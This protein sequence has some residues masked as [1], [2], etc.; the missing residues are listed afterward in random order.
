MKARKRNQSQIFMEKAIQLAET[1]MN[2]KD[3]G[4]FG[5]IL[6]KDNTII[7]EG[8]NKVTSSNDPTAHAEIVCIREA[9][10]YLQN[11]DLSDCEI[12]SS[13]EP[14]PMCLAA[15]YW[16]GIKRITYGADHNEAATYGFNDAFIY[17]E[18]QKDRS[19]RKIEMIQIMRNE[20]LA[21][22]KQ[23]EELEDKIT[24]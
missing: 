20:A 5:A 8:W 1:H 9:A 24:Y 11:F 6:V 12:F 14:C 21:G 19:A 15:A 18:L 3:G 22:F 23:W 16:A 7:A 17:K 10:T 13:C 2:A 4:P